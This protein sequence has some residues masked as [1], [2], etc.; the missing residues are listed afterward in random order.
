M[1]ASRLAP[2]ALLAVLLAGCGGGDDPAT[3]AG[4]STTAGPEQEVQAAAER[5]LETRDAAVVCA[6]LTTAGFVEE[7]FGGRRAACSRSAIADASEE[8]EEEVVAV[9][10]DG[11][12]AAVELRQAGGPA[13]G[14][15][16]HATFVREGETW[17]LDRFED[18][19]VRSILGESIVA[20]GAAGGTGAFT[21]PSLRDCMV[22]RVETLPAPAVRRILWATLNPDRDAA[23][24]ALNAQLAKCPD[25]LATYVT[26]QLVEGVFAGKGSPAFL[27]CA[28]RELRA[29]LSL[30]D[31]T[32]LA[33]RGNSSG[34]GSAAIG[35]LVLGV[36]RNCGGR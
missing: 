20:A 29:L 33:L 19:Y 5:L 14:A 21:E 4:T 36:Q 7:V 17:K 12:R 35:G 10:V 11:E 30:T 6:E 28:R 34:A 3:T 31:L 15:G 2:L 8:G 16:G 25:E 18:D 32:E 27:R 23:Y 9:E 24:A 26:D 1:L 22:D 13:D